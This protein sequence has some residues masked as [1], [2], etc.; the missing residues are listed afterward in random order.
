MAFFVRAA[1]PA[2]LQVR[3]T[4]SKNPHGCAEARS[5]GGL[6]RYFSRRLLGLGSRADLYRRRAI[7]AA[8]L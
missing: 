2:T 5:R 7:G 6:G 1:R 8:N 3:L 4:V